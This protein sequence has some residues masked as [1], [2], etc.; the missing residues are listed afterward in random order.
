MKKYY[1]Y[2]KVKRKKFHHIVLIGA[3]LVILLGSVFWFKKDILS[4]VEP[5]PGASQTIK[6]TAV[7]SE[8]S[9]P[10]P[11]VSDQTG[12]E[13]APSSPGTSQSAHDYQLPAVQNG[14]VP[15]ISRMPTREK[16]AFLTIDDGIVT[17]QGDAKLME[18]NGAKATLFLVYRFIKGDPTFFGNLAQATGSDIENHSY[19]HY[20]L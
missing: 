2:H 12:A 15:V 8:D 14:M 1:R 20:R 10:N 19:D 6:T 3:A 13:Q 5:A 11:V 17:S 18:D 7:D 4:F 9:L 16:V